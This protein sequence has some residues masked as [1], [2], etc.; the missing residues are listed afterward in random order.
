MVQDSPIVQSQLPEAHSGAGASSLK[1]VSPLLCVTAKK[2]CVINQAFDYLHPEH[3]NWVFHSPTQCVCGELGSIW[4]S[5]C[6]QHCVC[7]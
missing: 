7:E 3:A 2:S 1:K 5:T 4:W 6:C